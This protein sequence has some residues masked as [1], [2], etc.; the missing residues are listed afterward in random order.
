MKKLIVSIIMLASVFTASAGNPSNYTKEGNV[1]RV[2]KTEKSSTPEDTGFLW[3]DS[4]GN[5]YT[6][7]IGPSGACYV[8]RVSQKTGKQYK[9]YLGE[10]ISREICKSLGREYKPSK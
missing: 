7:Y 8:N 3:E 10:E 9:Y 4:K 2:E 6:I 5:Q 1:F